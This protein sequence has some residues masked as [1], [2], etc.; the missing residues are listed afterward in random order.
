M[1]GLSNSIYKYPWEK[2][3]FGKAYNNVKNIKTV[4]VE[5]PKKEKKQDSKVNRKNQRFFFAELKIKDN[6]PHLT[7][8]IEKEY[9]YDKVL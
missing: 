7:I 2:Y 1:K 5:M 9:K 6:C 3:K 8:L 4:K